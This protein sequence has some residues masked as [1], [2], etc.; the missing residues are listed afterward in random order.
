MEKYVYRKVKLY[1]HVRFVLIVLDLL[2]AL[3]EKLYYLFC[4]FGFSFSYPGLTVILLTRRIST[5]SKQAIDHRFCVFRIIR[6]RSTA[7]FPNY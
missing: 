2:E 1:I 7:P 5:T 3:R 6:K 4:L